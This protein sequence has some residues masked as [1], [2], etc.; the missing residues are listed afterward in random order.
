[1]VEFVIKDGTAYVINGTYPTP[2]ID[3]TLMTEEQFNW[4]VTE[5]AELALSVTKQPLPQTGVFTKLGSTK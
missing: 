4:L 2:D 5:I 1:M 3:L